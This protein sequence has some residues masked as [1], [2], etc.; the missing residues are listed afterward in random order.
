MCDIVF[1]D[2]PDDVYMH[3]ITKKLEQISI[4]EED[5]YVLEQ[6]TITKDKDEYGLEQIEHQ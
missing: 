2:D 5:E 4:A 3:P 1:I 6:Q